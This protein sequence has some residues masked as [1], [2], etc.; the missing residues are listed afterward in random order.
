MYCGHKS[1]KRI[2]SEGG[3]CNCVLTITLQ[4]HSVILGLCDSSHFQSNKM[5][6]FLYLVT[7]IDAYCL[8]IYMDVS[9]SSGLPLF[10]WAQNHLSTC[11]GLCLGGWCLSMFVMTVYKYEKKWIKVPTNTGLEAGQNFDV[12]FF[13]KLFPDECLR[14]TLSI[15]GQCI[16][17]WPVDVLP[18]VC[19]KEFCHGHRWR[20]QTLKNRI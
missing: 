4:I 5:H 17:P 14:L 3:L 12:W 19:M 2:E 16:A 6:V 13:D 18:A 1:T 9:H 20:L 15:T 8:Y 11:F 7:H 10:H